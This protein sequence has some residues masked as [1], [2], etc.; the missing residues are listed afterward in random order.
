MQ[1]PFKLKNC[2][3]K[4][5]YFLRIGAI[6]TKNIP[7]LFFYHRFCNEPDVTL[8]KIDSQT[9][10]WQLKQIKNEW[11]V[12]SLR[13]YIEFKK[14]GVCIPS[15]LV[16]LTVDDGYDD[17]Y[18]IAY[19]KLLKY[20]IPT[21][22]FPTVNFVEGKIWLW[23]DKLYFILRNSSKK[24]LTIEH[25]GNLLDFDLSSD[26]K[27]RVAW[28]KLCE[29]CSGINDSNKW[30]FIFSLAKKMNVDI[31][32]VP[33]S[34]Y[35]AVTWNQIK[36]M[37]SSGIEI[38]SHTLNHPILSQ[39]SNKDIIE[40]IYYSKIK[41]EEKIGHE[42]KT[43]CYPSGRAVD[44]NEKIAIEV[45]KAGYSGAVV[46]RRHSSDRN[47]DDLYRIPRIGVEVEKVDFLWKL[48]G[49]EFLVADVKSLLN[50]S[51]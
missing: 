15:K 27:L 13:D 40:E 6:L 45:R 9:F 14:S 48:Y 46:T 51:C 49:M 22:F 47:F 34:A 10:E 44:L 43:F 33:P 25:Y 12:C 35:R 26:K 39:I 37:S 38:G 41:I 29:F 36:E 24:N 31:P 16:I 32:Q 19:P 3:I 28:Q 21:T 42:V 1:F 7:R 4:L 17:F 20:K 18:E 5:P 30:E 8:Q 50:K 23:P 11:N 2:L